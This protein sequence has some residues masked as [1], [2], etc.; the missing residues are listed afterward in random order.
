VNRRLR[1][2]YHAT[3]AQAMVTS[4]RSIERPNRPNRRSEVYPQAHG[5]KEARRDQSCNLIIVFAERSPALAEPLYS[6]QKKLPVP[7]RSARMSA[8]GQTFAFRSP[9]ERRLLSAEANQA[10]TSQECQERS[11]TVAA[12][13]ADRLIQARDGTR[14][15]RI[16]RTD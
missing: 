15:V 12:H 3:S 6:D 5:G 11:L 8:P 7:A 13:D 1:R 14:R 4:L 16:I 10:L 2:E 9:S